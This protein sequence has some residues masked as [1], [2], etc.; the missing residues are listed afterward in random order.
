M[1]HRDET[2]HAAG[3]KGGEQDDQRDPE[4]EDMN[5]KIDPED[6]EFEDDE[7]EDEDTAD[8]NA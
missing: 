6:D 2:R 8:R 5:H 3:K 4:D 1:R 7:F